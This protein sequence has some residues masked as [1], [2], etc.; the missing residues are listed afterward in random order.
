[1]IVRE[2]A[3]LGMDLIRNLRSGRLPDTALKMAVDHSYPSNSEGV[4]VDCGI[5]ISV[6]PIQYQ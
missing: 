4:W 5:M 6:A 3:I 1:V 2:I